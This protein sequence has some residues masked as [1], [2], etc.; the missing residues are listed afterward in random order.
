MLDA[1]A[2]QIY[3][4]PLL[5]NLA[6]AAYGPPAIWNESLSFYTVPCDATSPAFAIVIDG[7]TFPVDARDMIIEDETGGGGCMAG[8]NNG[9]QYAPYVVGVQFLKNTLVVVDVG[10]GE[11]RVKARGKY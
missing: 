6:A 5:A 1:G 9:G 8:I 10:R 4:P 7:K 3:L 2:T 11:V